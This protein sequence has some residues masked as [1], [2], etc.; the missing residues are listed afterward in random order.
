MKKIVFLYTI[1]LG[2]FWEIVYVF[3]I[4]GA[5]LLITFLIKYLR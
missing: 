5:G 3:V 2:I 1:T 4:I